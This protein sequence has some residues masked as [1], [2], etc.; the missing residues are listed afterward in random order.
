MMELDT[1][2]GEIIESAAGALLAREAIP[3]DPPARVATQVVGEVTIGGGWTGRVVVAC[4][5]QLAH[6]FAAA[7]F[8]RGAELVT[9]SDVVDALSELTNIVGGN[10]KSLVPTT[11]HCTLSL[12]HVLDR[13]PAGPWLLERWFDVAGSRLH[14]CVAHEESR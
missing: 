14:V 8:D 7:M 6:T 4:D 5:R 11:E 3:C 10:F 1:Q 2:L 9:E 13:S 12:P